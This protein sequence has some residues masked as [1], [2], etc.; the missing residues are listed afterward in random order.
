LITN[1]YSNKQLLLNARYNLKQVKRNSISTDTVKSTNSNGSEELSNRENI[2]VNEN[3]EN[4]NIAGPT[5]ETIDEIPVEAEPATITENEFCEDKRNEEIDDTDEK[6]K[7]SYDEEK[8]CD[9]NGKETENVE[10]NDFK[11]EDN[12]FQNAI[13]PSIELPSTGDLIQET[14]ES[15]P[16][17]TSIFSVLNGN[18]NQ[19][20]DK[21]FEISG[22]E[23]VPFQKNNEIAEFSMEHDIEHNI[24]YDNDI[25]ASH[26]MEYS[27]EYKI[28]YCIEYTMDKRTNYI[29]DYN[30]E[31]SVDYKIDYALD[32]DSKYGMDND[33]KYTVRYCLKT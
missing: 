2:Q 14:S 23:I 26:K 20:T 30:M 27:I 4:N 19:L 6:E 33:L 16:V 18:S 28:D 7:V 21:R 5:Q 15:P 32:Y 22:E 17:S 9:E 12:S 8:T 24:D 31:Y 29:L 3:D 25:E 13:I 10:E 1:G 11:K